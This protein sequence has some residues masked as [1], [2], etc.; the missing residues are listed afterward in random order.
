MPKQTSPRFEIFW[1][2]YPLRNGRRL[3]RGECF[4]LFQTFTDEDQLLCCR[5]AGSYGQSYMGKQHKFRPEPRDPIRFL[6]KDWW[7][8]WLIPEAKP[9]QFRSLF[10]PCED[11]ALP[12]ETHCQKHKDTI[13]KLQRVRKQMEAT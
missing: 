1:N 2:L 4:E 3:G 8:D 10:E 5:A 6:K 11:M 7:R 9:C 12:G 13:A